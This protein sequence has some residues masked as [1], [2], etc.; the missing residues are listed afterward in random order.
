MNV[1]WLFT[2]YISLHFLNVQQT[3][4][5]DYSY[6]SYYKSAWKARKEFTLW[7]LFLLSLS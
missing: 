3:L 7:V 6:S 4:S 1:S 5:F 2:V